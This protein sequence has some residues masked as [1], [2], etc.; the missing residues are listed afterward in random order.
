MERLLLSFAF[1]LL[2]TINSVAQKADVAIGK[3]TYELIH[4]RDTA[5]RGKPYKETMALILGRNASA[6]HSITKQQ[7]EEMF[8]NQIANQVKSATDPNHL[9]LTITGGGAVSSEEYYQYTNDKKLYTEEQIVNYYLVEEPLPV[10]KWKIQKDTLS[11]GAL[12]CQKAT[13]HFKGRE[14]EAWFCTDLPFHAGPWK[15]NG[16]PGLI[17]EASDTKKEVIFKFN[18]FEDISN[19]NQT[20]LPPADDIKTT[21]QDLARLKEARA[22]D[23]AG[24]NKA[25]RGG[26]TGKRRGIAAAMDNIDPSKISSINVVKATDGNSR[27][28]NNPIELPEKK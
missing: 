28:N 16:L 5:N 3:A 1:L 9:N 11:I 14:Y 24:F 8:A 4:V 6:Y 10:I 17:I 19:L 27:V 25:S 15:L 21:P 26:G 13:A 12:H 2:L 18:S 22:K 20:I 23:P 7:Q